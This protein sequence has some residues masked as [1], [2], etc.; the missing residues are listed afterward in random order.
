MSEVLFTLLVINL[1]GMLSPGPDMIMVIRYGSTGAKR[2][3]LCCI[4]GIMTGFCAHLLLAVFGVSL[5]ISQAPMVFTLVKYAGAAYLIYLGIKA[6][7]C[8]N[9]QIDATCKGPVKARYAYLEGLLCNLLNPKV[10]MFLVATF[11]QIVSPDTSTGSKLFFAATIAIEAIVVWALLMK[12]IYSGWLNQWL[13]KNQQ[14]INKLSGGIL[15]GL[16]SLIGIQM[17]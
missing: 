16:G 13:Q 14:R 1:L 17:S 15:V 10:L 5:L 11:T 9:K 3:T 4:L 12:F 8:K 2:T 7:R 6:W